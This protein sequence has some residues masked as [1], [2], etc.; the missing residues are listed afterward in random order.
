MFGC[1]HSFAKRRMFIALDAQFFHDP[2]AV[3]IYKGDKKE[4]SVQVHMCRPAIHTGTV[5]TE[6][7]FFVFPAVWSAE[8]NHSHNN[9]CSMQA[10]C[11]VCSS[12]RTWRTNHNHSEHSLM[13][14][15]LWC[16]S[17]G[18]TCRGRT[19]HKYSGRSL[20]QAYP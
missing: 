7:F 14:A 19:S 8:S 10:S 2:P 20:M 3:Y 15:N 1:G 12:G 13:Q 5:R 16:F 4:V 18:R 11:G 9:H 17:S 6:S